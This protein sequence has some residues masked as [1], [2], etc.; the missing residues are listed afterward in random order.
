MLLRRWRR[1]DAAAVAEAARDPEIRRFSHLPE[2]FDEPAL[3]G[4]V[5]RTSFELAAGTA[6]RLI[7]ADAQA[8]SQVL[9]AI[10][11]FDLS[12][13]RVEGQIGYWVAPAA[14]RR[15]WPPGR[16]R[17]SPRGRSDRAACAS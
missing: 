12:P 4:W 5:E 15:A 7:V 9:G 14:R 10:A 6:L 1:A 8:E 3:A 17:C 13:D 11:L 2:P 16:S